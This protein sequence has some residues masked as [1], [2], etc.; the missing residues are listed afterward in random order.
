MGTARSA[1]RRAVVLARPRVYTSMKSGLLIVR[2]PFQAWLSAAVLEQENITE[3][4][5]LYLTNQDAE[6]DRH[7]YSVLSARANRSL[8]CHA[9]PRW[10]D[11]CTHVHWLMQART[12]MRDYKRDV[13][14]LSSI[15]NH[16]ISSI[17]KRQRKAELVTFDDG[18][19]NI[20]R[21]SAYHLDQ[22]NWRVRLYRRLFGAYDLDE[23]KQTIARHY[24]IHPQFHNIVPKHKLRAIRREF[25]AI[26][27][28]VGQ[29]SLRSEPMLRF[30]I[31]QPFEGVLTPSQIDKI[32][33]YAR[34]VGIDFYVKHPRETNPL[35]VGAPILAK[36]GLIAEES[37]LLASE[38][39]RPHLIGCFSGVLLNIGKEF[40]HRTM[41]FFGD[42][43]NTPELAHIA[44]ETG[45]ETVIF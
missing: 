25:R 17:A 22:V 16:V 2:T 19:A 37:I 35:Q 13:T 39:Y 30:F 5:L 34:D 18:S 32:T 8:Y 43:C 4:D 23:I 7:Y 29:L 40:A 20:V 45:C 12:W 6:E 27:R 42:A 21:S 11:I 1:V 15:D 38:G 33:S 28:G 44:K 41:L 3:L 24:T 10:C 31:G 26:R 36:R 9:P 14:V